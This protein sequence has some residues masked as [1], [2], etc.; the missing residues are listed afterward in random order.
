M[1]FRHKDDLLVTTKVLVENLV[2][3]RYDQ[4]AAVIEQSAEHVII[5]GIYYYITVFLIIHLACLHFAE[6]P[7]FPCPYHTIKV[8]V[9]AS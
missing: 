8:Y 9:W 6:S 5:G 3:D 7:G 2:D 4:A 1:G